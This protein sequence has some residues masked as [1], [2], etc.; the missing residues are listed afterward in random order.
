MRISSR[1]G[2]CP[3]CGDDSFSPSRAHGIEVVLKVLLPYNPYRCSNCNTRFWAPTSFKNYLGNIFYLCVFLSLL[4]LLFSQ[5]L[6]DD[7]SRSAFQEG[8]LSSPTG[9]EAELGS[10]IGNAIKLEQELNQTS[11]GVSE[12]EVAKRYLTQKPSK[13]LQEK[14]V[15]EEKLEQKASAAA[16]T[17]VKPLIEEPVVENRNPEKTI[18]TKRPLKLVEKTSLKGG[19]VADE[20]AKAIAFSAAN[21]STAINKS[22]LQTS[23]SSRDVVLSQIENWRAAWENQDVARYLASYSF[24]FK[25]EKGMPYAV[26]QKKRRATLLK[27]TWV[28]LATSNFDMKFSDNNRRVTVR[29]N[30]DYAA[31]NYADKSRKELVLILQGGNWNI[32]QERSL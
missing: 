26:W 21:S 17:R 24:R 22:K 16:I 12:T 13:S 7:S 6:F 28:K 11:G 8:G 14:I 3:E 19:S 2:E 20:N 9:S 1:K 10:T 27:P 29:F 18:A 4:A 15:V 23:Q 30:Q 32:I 25:P 31:S 5:K